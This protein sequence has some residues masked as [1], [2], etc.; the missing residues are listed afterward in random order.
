M[1]FLAAVLGMVAVL[2]V[3]FSPADYQ[4]KKLSSV[5]KEQAIN[6]LETPV[7]DNINKLEE[8][9]LTM[10]E[11]DIRYLSQTDQLGKIFY[12]IAYLKNVAKPHCV[13]YPCYTNWLGQSVRIVVCSENGNIDAPQIVP[14]N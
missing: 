9:V 11:K 5:V 3:G 1:F 8:F 6:N 10:N 2:S 7:I 14:C 4:V 12:D 13:S